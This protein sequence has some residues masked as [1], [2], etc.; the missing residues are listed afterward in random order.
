MPIDLHKHNHNYTAQYGDEPEILSQGRHVLLSPWN[1]FIAIKR[2]TE[3]VIKHGPIHIIRV[4]SG[5]LGYGIDMKSGHPILLTQGEH[6]IDSPTFQWVKFITL[7]D[8]QTILANLTIIRVETGYVGY[9]Y[10]QG[11][12]VI[13]KPGV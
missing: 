5:Q 6:I 8:Q 9:C 4:Q 3:P 1:K 13:L 11:Q 10:K 12:L 2:L 7:R